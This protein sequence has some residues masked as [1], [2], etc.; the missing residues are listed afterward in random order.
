MIHS[1][2]QLPV[3][4]RSGGSD[5]SARLGRRKINLHNMK[6]K[7][8]LT[9]LL[10]VATHLAPVGAFFLTIASMRVSLILGLACVALDGY[11][12]L[13]RHSANRSQ[14]IPPRFAESLLYFAAR[15][16]D[17][18]YLVGDLAEEYC[19]IQAR[20]GFRAAK[21]W[22]YRQIVTSLL[23][24]FRSYCYKAIGAPIARAWNG[25]RLGD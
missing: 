20:F 14:K 8:R 17:L 11:L 22:Y 12:L 1:A 16:E 25:I 18:E 2:A 23:P 13:R 10:V 7:M 9:A 3:I 19:E 15:R 4:T 6:T 24:L 21:F 5:D